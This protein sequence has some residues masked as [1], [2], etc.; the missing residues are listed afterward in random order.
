MVFSLTLGPSFHA[1]SGEIKPDQWDQNESAPA[2]CR[3]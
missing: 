1:R 2:V 3:G